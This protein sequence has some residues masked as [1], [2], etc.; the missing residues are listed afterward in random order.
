M[1]ILRYKPG[2]EAPASTTYALVGHYGESTDFVMWLNQGERFPFVTVAADYGPF[3][4]VRVD[5]AHESTRA[6]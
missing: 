5:I 6:A 1:P 4:Y 2:D 3:W